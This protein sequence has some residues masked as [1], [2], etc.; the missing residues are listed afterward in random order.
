M[1]EAI[2]FANSNASQFGCGEN[3]SCGGKCGC[4]KSRSRGNSGLGGG[5]YGPGGFSGIG[6][7]A[8]P[9]LTNV[10]ADYM[11]EKIARGEPFYLSPEVNSNTLTADKTGFSVDG[12]QSSGM[13]FFFV[14]FLLAAAGV[15]AKVAPVVIAAAG[16]KAAVD[17]AAANKKA[18]SAAQ[19]Q[20]QA[21]ATAEAEAAAAAAAL[22][23]Q[24]VAIPPAIQTQ[25]VSAAKA[26]VFGGV[27]KNLLLAGAIGL[28]ALLLLK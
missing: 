2:I 13:G 4:G 27:D 1:R 24:Q 19:A 3:C 7:N 16:A 26:D 20:A 18:A 10:F 22:R 21:Q 9:R 8:Y 6:E 28:V 5:V 14:P 23:S 11:R 15:A 12:Q 17:T 25:V